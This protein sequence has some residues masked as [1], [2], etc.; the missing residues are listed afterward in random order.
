V[1]VVAGMATE[2]QAAESP[3]FLFHQ[4]LLA[5]LKPQAE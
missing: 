4:S 1:V 3:A 5:E 2:P